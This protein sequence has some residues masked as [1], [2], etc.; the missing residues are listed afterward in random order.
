MTVAEY[1]I[2]YLIKS[3]SDKIKMHADAELKSHGLTLSQSRILGFLHDRGGRATQKEIEDFLDVAHPTVVGIVARME[4][5]GFL[6]TDID[7]SDK[8]NKVVVMAQQAISLDRDMGEMIRR[9]EE[10][11]VAGLT[12]A[13]IRDL[14]ASLNVIYRNIR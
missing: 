12:D 6:T 3:I 7:A 4:Q 14:T 5:K 13:Q 1:P 8:R 11:M 10:R 9:N 2:G